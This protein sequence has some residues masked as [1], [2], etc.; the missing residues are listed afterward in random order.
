MARLF[1]SYKSTTSVQRVVAF[2]N[3][4]TYTVP[5]GGTIQV[6]EEVPKAKVLA[7]QFELVSEGQPFKTAP[8]GKGGK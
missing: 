1:N 4:L 5:P 3:G 8:V 2:S 6:P 7:E